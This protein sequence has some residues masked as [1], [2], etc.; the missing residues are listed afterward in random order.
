M[1]NTSGWNITA[2]KTAVMFQPLKQSEN[3]KIV[4]GKSDRDLPEMG[5]GRKE[6]QRQRGADGFLR[7]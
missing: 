1:T 2:D 5:G 4:S 6:D 7:R 3:G